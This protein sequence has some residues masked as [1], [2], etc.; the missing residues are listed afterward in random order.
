MGIAPGIG[1]ALIVVDVQNDFL[2]GGALA[3]VGGDA[4]IAPLNAVIAVFRNKGLP[5]VAT[6]D[7]HPPD[8]C[9]FKARGGPWPPHCIAGSAGAAFPTRLRLPAEATIISKAATAGADA[10]SGFEGT[11]LADTLRALGVRRLFVGGLASDYCVLQTVLDGLAHGFEV[12]VL[13]DAIR[14]VAQ[15][16]GDERA[17]IDAMV[18]HGAQPGSAAELAFPASG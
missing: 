2:P 6:R 17:A 7:W 15:R 13:L 10:Y 3:V 16:A 12:V 5:I 9:S 11:M 4:V 14:A 18:A 8:H 1:D